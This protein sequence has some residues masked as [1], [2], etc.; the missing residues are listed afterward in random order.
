MLLFDLEAEFGQE[1]LNYILKKKTQFIAE[2]HNSFI[3]YDDR[4][5]LSKKIS[6]ETLGKLVK[7]SS[8]S[9]QPQHT[10][11]EAIDW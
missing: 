6:A 2:D 8:S 1:I 5:N 7:Y 9:P 11:T 3:K 4:E 10:T